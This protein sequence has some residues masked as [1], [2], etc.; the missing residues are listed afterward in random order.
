MSDDLLLPNFA[1]PAVQ[2][3]FWNDQ[4]E[5]LD[6]AHAINDDSP[7]CGARRFACTV[8]EDEDGLL[9]PWR[10]DN[11]GDILGELIYSPSETDFKLCGNLPSASFFCPP[12]ITTCCEFHKPGGGGRETGNARGEGPELEL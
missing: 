10:P 6:G 11:S 2:N 4:A 5:V 12:V 3:A 7:N 9:R 8:G 1:S